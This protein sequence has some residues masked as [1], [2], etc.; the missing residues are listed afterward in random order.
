MRS[1]WH[2]TA[3]V[4]M[5]ALLLTACDDNSGGRSVGQQLDAALARTEQ[6]GAE[7]VAKTR[8]IAADARAQ[9]ESSEVKD[10]LKEAGTSASARFG[11][12][13]ITAK[14]MAGL[15]RDG[16]LSALGIDVRTYAGEVEMRGS[17]PSVAA[18]LRAEQI[19]TN[20]DGVSKVKN[21]LTVPPL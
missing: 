13:A 17:A 9:V 10:R 1:A 4:A 14:V 12:A 8:E 16:D 18:K 3:L 11:D 19:A 20:V 21:L 6:A 5:S 2:A 7:A 15:A